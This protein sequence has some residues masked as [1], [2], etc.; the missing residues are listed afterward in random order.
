MQA[1]EKDPDARPQ[2]AAGLGSAL[3]AAIESPGQ[4]LRHAVALYSEHFPSFVKI[5]VLGYAPL[6][7]IL[8]FNVLSDRVLPIQRWDPLLQN[9][10]GVTVFTAIIVVSIFSY[11]VVSAATVP[12]VVQLMIAPLRQIR[13]ATAL[14]A[15]KRRWVV[16]LIT[17]LVV[18][19]LILAGSLLFVI[20]GV[21]VAVYFSLYAPVVIMEAG[22]VWAS[23]V[24]A[25]RLVKRAWASVLTVTLLQFALPILVWH[26]AVSTHFTFKLDDNYNPKELG[27]SFSMSGGSALYQL[28]NLFVTP[29][30]AIMISLLYL[31]SR[32]AGGESL[33]A[34]SEQFEALDIPRSKWQA[35]M[36]RASTASAKR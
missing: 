31:K 36:R 33:R 19:V 11:F 26:A 15:V 3:S 27:F 6:I 14:M 24:R 18:V 34:T 13:L 4:L 35:R 32:Q 17:S 10:V 22:G 20:P 1:L 9:A 16:F 25:G 21:F 30:T 7:A 5:S 28:L 8:I 29:L 12:V 23:L 2:T